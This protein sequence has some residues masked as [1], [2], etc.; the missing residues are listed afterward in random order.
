M[1][2]GIIKVDDM[3]YISTNDTGLKLD[4]IVYV[5]Y[6]RTIL[7]FACTSRYY[8]KHTHIL[9]IRDAREIKSYKSMQVSN[10]SLH[11]REVKALADNNNILLKIKIL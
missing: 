9:M 5:F 7:S 6:S 11:E 2:R 8:I 3:I 4:D 10:F 1:S